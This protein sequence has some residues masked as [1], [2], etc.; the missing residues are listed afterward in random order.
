M[1]YAPIL[2]Q[3]ADRQQF[4]ELL[5]NAQ[6]YW[7]E[8]EDCQAL[9]LLA[10]AHAQ[11]GQRHE[12]LAWLAE[13][14]A[15]LV[16][17]DLDARVDLAGG[18]CLLQRPLDATPLL[19]AALEAQP[20][21]A[22]AL[23]RLAWCRMH[24][25]QAELARQLYQRSAELAPQRL[26]VWSALARLCLE[27]G[28]T[29]AAQQ[30]LDA[31]IERL[32]D[33]QGELPEAV[34]AQ[35]SAQ[36]RGL[37]LEIWLAQDGLARAEQWLDA[38]RH[39]LSEDEWSGLLCGYGA[40]LAGH[41]RHAAAEEALRQGLKHYPK[42]SAL[43]SQLAELAQV[44]GRT[45][46]AIQLLRRL[47]QLP[48][49]QEA[50]AVSLWLRLSAACLQ[51]DGEQARQAAQKAIELAQGLQAGESISE[52]GL[53]GLRLQAKQALAQVESQAQQFEV[54]ERL[55]GEVLAENPWS[56]PALQGLGQ[57]QMQRGKIDEAVALFERI[58]QVDPP[59]GYASLINARQF[60]EDVETLERM[61]QAARQPSLEGS[62]RAGLLLQL[63]AAWEKRKDYDRAFALAKEAN[64][65]SRKL[66]RYDGKAHRNSCARIRHAFSRSLYQHRQGCGLDSTLPVY[67]VGMPRSGTTLVEQILAGH[68][69]IFGA[70]E[71]G[72][73]PQRIAGLNRWERHSGSGRH[74][75]DCVDDLSPYVTAGI[76][77]GIL[78]ELREYAPEARHIVDKLPHNFEN[79]G[80]IKFLFPRAKIISVRRDPRD[81]A[82][83]N[84]FT[85]YQA[86]HGGMGF[87]YDLGAIGEQLADHNLLMHHWQQLFPGEILEINYED[88]VG[89]LE[90]SARKMLEY[91][92]VAWESQVLAFNELE[93][94]V[95]TASVW[96]VR[97]PVY[98]TSKAKWLRYQNHLA[99]LIQGTNAR[100]EWDPIEMVTL[101]EPGLLN[102]GV[103]LYRQ[104]RLDEAEY[105][106]KKLL[107]H[108]PEHAAANFMVGLIYVRKG[109]LKAGIE[110]MEAG[111]G[112]CP[113]NPNWRK[114]LIQAYQLAGDTE[115]T[116]ALQRTRRTEPNDDPDDQGQPLGSA[117]FT[118]TL[119]DPG[120]I[121]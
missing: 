112:K 22:L 50:Q 26:P 39:S 60:P 83:S 5:A 10:L 69:Q 15:R 37:Q 12:A 19:E 105:R 35:F 28:D 61:E 54:A 84:Y 59:R 45:L 51:Q 87:A 36:F 70:G 118:E 94:P 41:D 108:I 98:Q 79:I 67:V 63:A 33:V 93:R 90:G 82:I 97:Q 21:H 111:H 75:P 74:Y 65:A 103:E 14:E 121:V 88:V 42:N 17:L 2:R 18:Y 27:A 119:G 120:R 102:E 57:Q 117:T 24:D 100:I 99:P 11:L 20:E 47:I 81:I 9:P 77:N 34:V 73:I 32:M 38:R 13:A 58:R 113:W 96:Q 101:P 104:E 43:L 7:H 76:A 8:A 64:D 56:V 6:A 89:D 16:Q 3:L 53:L 49:M 68:S 55:F 110:L 46:Q 78:D 71:L 23:A 1:S 92:G 31:A 115:K 95:K 62:L 66:L 80:L 25:G 4:G 52:A 30:A 85:D 91:I 86:K 107:H 109:H 116:E 44:Q 48:D 106:F 29:A 40:L 72:V 114:D